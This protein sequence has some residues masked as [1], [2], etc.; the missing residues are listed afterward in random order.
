MAYP[1]IRTRTSRTLTRLAHF[2]D[3]HVASDAKDWG[4]T[5]STVVLCDG[6]KTPGFDP[7]KFNTSV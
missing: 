3:S 7:R 1:R 4:D 5:D 2:D 6:D